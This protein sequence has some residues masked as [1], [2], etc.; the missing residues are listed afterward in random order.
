MSDEIKVSKNEMLRRMQD[1]WN[2]FQAYLKTLTNEQMTAPVDDVG[3]TVKDHLVHLAA[4]EDGV[5]ALL[6]GQDRLERMHV[7]S[8]TWKK[9]DFDAMN[10]V[11]QSH[12]KGQ[13]LAGALKMLRDAHQRLTEAVQQ[14]SDKDLKRPYRTFDQS[15]TSETPVYALIVGNS[16][17]HY[18]EHKPW[19]EAIVARSR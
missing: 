16:Y 9:G 18:A 1:G 10:A 4:W 14:L 5:A 6:Q 7:D 3:W 2:D 11:M 8:E 15:S 19:I 12:Y 13:S 17:D